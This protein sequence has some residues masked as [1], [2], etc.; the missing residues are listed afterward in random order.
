MWPTKLKLTLSVEKRMTTGAIVTAPAVLE[1][2]ENIISRT[3]NEGP[4]A[5]SGHGVTKTTPVR[6]IFVGKVVTIGTG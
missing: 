6:S 1:T 5:I 4:A 3:G 2:V